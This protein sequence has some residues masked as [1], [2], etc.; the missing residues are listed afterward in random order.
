M[1]FKKI[2]SKIKG[3]FSR[4]EDPLDTFLSQTPI[5]MLNKRVITDPKGDL[6]ELL[7]LL[8]EEAREAAEV[9][10]VRTGISEDPEYIDKTIAFYQDKQGDQKDIVQLHLLKGDPQAAI[11]VYTDNNFF[12]EDAAT[13]AREHLGVEAAIK[14]YQDAITKGDHPKY[15]KLLGELFREEGQEEDAQKHFGEAIQGYMEKGSVVDALELERAEGTIEGVLEIYQK[16]AE[17]GQQM[18][19][20]FILEGAEFAEAND[21]Q[22]EADQLYESALDHLL[23]EIFVLDKQRIV[24]VAEKVGNPKKLLAAYQ[25]TSQ[26]AKAYALAV[27]E[28]LDTIAT[29]I[30]E[31]FRVKPAELLKIAEIAEEAGRIQDASKSYSRAG[32]EKTGLRLQL[33]HGDAASVLNYCENMINIEYECK[34][35]EN[36]DYFLMGMKAAEVMEN[37]EKRTEIG[38]KA[39]ERFAKLGDFARASHF[40]SQIGKNKEADTYKALA[41]LTT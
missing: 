19:I 17:K 31:D 37:E 41:K 27:E 25:K 36:P 15:H 11:A 30:V 18:N 1:D 26:S 22:E 13:L 16:K 21:F 14:V 2:Y 39:I 5:P 3:A 40:A 7:S 6:E 29:G 35:F 8:P 32:Q 23:A 9:G 4:E 38:N 12:I 24:K 28:G 20:D 10:S 33:K 34:I